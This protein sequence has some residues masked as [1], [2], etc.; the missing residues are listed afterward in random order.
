MMY[1]RVLVLVLSLVIC[2]LHNTINKL[3]K[4]ILQAY[5]TSCNESVFNHLELKLVRYVLVNMF[6][7]HYKCYANPQNSMTPASVVFTSLPLIKYTKCYALDI[8]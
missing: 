4:L 8:T 7:T 5:M 1:C 2:L 6:K 3:N